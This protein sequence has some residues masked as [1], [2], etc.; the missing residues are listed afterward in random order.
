[1]KFPEETIQ[2]MAQYRQQNDAVDEAV[3]LEE[4]HEYT[5]EELALAANTSVRN[6]RAYQD[7]G[8]LPPP[9]LRGRKG[10]YN[11][12]HLSRLRVIANLLDRGYTLASILDLI[13]GL[14]QGIGLPEILG[15]ESAI[16]SPWAK[17]AAEVIPMTQ[18]VKMFGTQLTPANIRLA[19]EL[20][21]AKVQGTQVRVSSMSTLKVAADLCAMGIPMGDQ[22]EILR[23]SRDNVEKVAKEFVRLISDNVLKPYQ[24]QSLP[25]KEEF[26]KIIDLIWRMRPMAEI[27]VKAELGR[28]MEM[29]ASN[30]LADQLEGIMKTLESSRDT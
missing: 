11:N 12:Q 8:L 7:K 2:N 13:S 26:P 24:Q 25:P 27:V 18:M 23:M 17:E 10:I 30:I 3:S 14:E 16:N 20:G 22:L 21:I 1:M 9:A 28:A 19:G 4:K 5:V 29:A 15:M 6:I